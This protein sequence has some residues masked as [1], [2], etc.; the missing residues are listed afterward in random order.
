MAAG[1]AVAAVSLNAPCDWDYA[2]GHALLRGAGG[3]LVDQE[4]R[5]VT[6]GPE[7]ASSVRRCFG[8]PLRVV[9]E[10]VARDWT[11]GPR[12]GESLCWPSP[13]RILADAGVLDRAQGC[14]LGQVAGDSLGSLVEFQ[15]PSA[16]GRAYPEGL[17]SLADGGTWNTLAGQPTDDSELALALSRSI[18]ATGRYSAE[19]AALAYAA[20]YR[21]RP[22]DVGTT[23]SQTLGRIHAGAS[24]EAARAACGAAAR[25]VAERGGQANGSL[26]RISPLGVWGHALPA[27]T[28]GDLARQD[29]ALTHAHPV[30]QDACAAYTVAVGHAVST[31]AGAEE[32]WRVACQWARQYGHAE[33]LA[34]L[35]AAAQAPPEDCTRHQG[36]VRLALQNAFFRLLH[37]PSLEDG[38]VRTVACGG[39]TDTN[40]A[41]AGAL[42]GAVHGRSQVPRDWEWGVLT[43]RP[44]PPAPQPR[45]Q[46]YWP[47]DILVQAE[48]LAV[49]GLQADE[50]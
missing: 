24:G 21:S 28:L 35:E 5:P 1:E 38:V 14:L 32:V 50:P 39:D 47:V 44:M 22:F 20:W 12:S 16:I 40:G 45:P 42:L 30:C 15:S 23:T 31:G 27:R 2:G 37:S 11:L 48:H 33:V 26:M 6:Y 46:D 34:T 8:G 25:Q 43:C 36:W 49:L 19:S 9:R 17:R 41:I 18:L 29:S 7:G 10:L 3:E 4:G 13:Q